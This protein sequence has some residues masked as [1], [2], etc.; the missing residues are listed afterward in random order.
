MEANSNTSRDILIRR[1]QAIRELTEWADLMDITIIGAYLVGDRS[2]DMSTNAFVEVK[3][4]KAPKDDEAEEPVSKKKPPNG[5]VAAFSE[6]SSVNRTRQK[7]EPR[8]SFFH[9]RSTPFSKEK[10]EE[11]MAKEKEKGKERTPKEKRKTPA[12][13]L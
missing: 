11:M 13:K 4:S 7:E 10:W 2:V 12:Y 9:P 5:K 1:A 3:R 8:P 6:E